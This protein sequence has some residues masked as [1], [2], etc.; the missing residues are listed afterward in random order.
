MNGPVEMV[1]SLS[2]AHLRPRR[3]PKCCT[4]HLII[5]AL[6]KT[7]LY[8]LARFNA[9]QIHCTLQN[10][11]GLSSSSGCPLH[12]ELHYTLHKASHHPSIVQNSARCAWLGCTFYYLHNIANSTTLQSHIAQSSSSSEY[13]AKLC[14]MCLASLTFAASQ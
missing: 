6:C 12:F 5:Q 14:L 1:I 9:M 7:L 13:C 10:S 3:K 11:A 2:P 4:K 8:Q